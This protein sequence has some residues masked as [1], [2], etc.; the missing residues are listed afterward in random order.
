M[1]F[2]VS[3]RRLTH[4]EERRRLEPIGTRQEPPGTHRTKWPGHLQNVLIMKSGAEWNPSEPIRN[5]PEPIVQSGQDACKTYSLF[6][7]V[8]CGAE[9]GTRQEPTGT[10]HGTHLNSWK[11]LTE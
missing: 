3:D 9:C 6:K 5:P 7:V 4:S 2:A 11:P 1:Y 10:H 8:R